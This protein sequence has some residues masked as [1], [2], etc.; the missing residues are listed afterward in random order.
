MSIVHQ[1]LAEFEHECTT[2]RKFLERLPDDKLDWRPH[3]KSMTAGQLV[4]HIA[5]VPG[6]VAQLTQE[7][8]VPA[9]D[10]GRPNLQPATTDE[11]IKAFDQSNATVRQ[12]LPT[13]TDA[14]MQTVWKMMLGDQPMLALPRN[15]D[16]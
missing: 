4:L 9:P 1:M 15:D 7:D 12:I 13:Y 5:V 14:Q 8:V 2:T 11:I 3:A 10:F 16:P 6:Q